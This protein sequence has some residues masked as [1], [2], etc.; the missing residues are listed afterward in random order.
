MK[1]AGSVFR[2]LRCKCGSKIRI[3]EK[4]PLEKNPTCKKCGNPAE[5]STFW[6][7]SFTKPD[8]KEAQYPVG[9]YLDQAKDEL[10]RVMGDLV[11]GKFSAKSSC[12]SW[13]DAVDEFKKYKEATTKPDTVGFYM[14]HLNV[15]APYFKHLT[16]KE[17]TPQMVTDYILERQKKVTN[18]TINHDVV[19]LKVML[20]TFVKGYIR[21]PKGNKYITENPLANYKMLQNNDERVV[22]YTNEEI[23]KLIDHATHPT[24]KPLVLL[25]VDA[26]LRKRTIITLEKSFVNWE[27]GRLEIPASRRK[28]GRYVHYVIMTSRLKKALTELYDGFTDEQRASKYIFPAPED[29]EKFFYSIEKPWRKTLKA[30]GIKEKR[31]HD[32]KHTAGTLVYEATGDIYATADFLDHADINMSKK[33]A[34][35]VD[36]KRIEVMKKFE[37]LTKIE[38]DPS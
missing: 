27:Q 28:R 12:I 36:A 6:Y 32:L 20:N 18:T 14:D 22:A 24:I 25:G 1:G 23:N 4:Q 3:R 7:V 37:A 33:Y 9:P 26:G 16:I 5:Y 8:G 29:P 2:Y 10:K 34:H 17:I 19:S 30:S 38:D 13:S 35:Q 15:L 31:L 11:D 21:D